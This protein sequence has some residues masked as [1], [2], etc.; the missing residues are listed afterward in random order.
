MKNITQ[1]IAKPDT[2]VDARYSVQMIQHELLVC[3]Y[4]SMYIRTCIQEGT[5]SFATINATVLEIMRKD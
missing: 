1:S 2:G 3:R 4:V 5:E